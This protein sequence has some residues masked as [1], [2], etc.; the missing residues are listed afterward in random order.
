MWDLPPSRVKRQAPRSGITESEPLGYQGSLIFFI[1]NDTEK[2]KELN[3][4]N[5]NPS[6][7]GGVF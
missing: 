1:L 3:R 2:Y 7:H 5:H 4:V 6:A